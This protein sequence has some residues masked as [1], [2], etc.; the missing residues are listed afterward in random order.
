MTILSAAV[1]VLRCFSTTRPDVTVTDLVSLLG[2]P[3][4]NASRLLR[5][6]RDEGL[7]ET[8]GDTKR[9]RPSVLINQVG[10]M[11]RYAASLIDRAD[12][13]VAGVSEDVGHTGY[14][15]VRRGTEVLGVTAHA[16]KHALRVV[17]TIGDRLP[18]FASSTGRALLARLSDDDVRALYANGFTPPSVTSPQD[19]SDLLA[20][21]AFTRAS[22]YAE[23][24]N[25]AVS[26]VRAIS[27]AVGDPATG[28]EVA[29]CISFPD[30][31][32]APEERLA[33]I[34]RLREGA[35]EIAALT[36]DALF[37]TAIPVIAEENS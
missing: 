33:I 27:V 14:I 12:T 30:A 19:I 6:M 18:A 28:D 32:V 20:R 4:S 22:G 9:Y 21:L 31:M 2:M 35:A 8:V 7:L 23:S 15:S 34:R 1:A 5:A 11:Y 16:G 10:Q 29:L 13:V 25:E 36:N 24:R 17:T 37:N 26:G 3:K